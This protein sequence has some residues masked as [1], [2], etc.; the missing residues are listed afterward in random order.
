MQDKKTVTIAVP[1]FNEELMIEE[2]YLRISSVMKSLDKYDYEI[3]FFDDGSTD[4]SRKKIEKLC[5]EDEKVKAVFYKKNF[6]YSKT[7]FYCMQ[8]AKG[9]CAILIHADL[10]NP[11]ELIPQMIEKWENGSDAVIGIKNKSRENKI[12]FFIRTVFYFVM[13]AFFGMNLVPHAT[14]FELLDKSFINVQKNSKYKNPFLRSIIQE[15]ASDI[16]Y[17]YYTQDKRRKG[18]T[19]FNISKYYD[20]AICGIVNMSKNLPRKFLVFGIIMALLSLAEFLI[21]F[22]PSLYLGRV[23]DIASCVILRLILFSLSLLIVFISVISEYII[24]MADTQNNKPFIV[25]SK[26]INY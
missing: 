20:F 14:D 24:A 4:S 15:Y 12:M 1:V 16:S 3:V 2:V 22:V 10:Q 21:F 26:R 6:G 17:V 19:K 8:Q 25:E 11:P 23:G 5:S 7:I 9:D 18:K 13:N